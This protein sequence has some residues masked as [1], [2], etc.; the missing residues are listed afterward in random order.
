[1][2]STTPRGLQETQREQSKSVLRLGML[3]PG[4]VFWRIT[5]CVEAAKTSIQWKNSSGEV[6]GQTPHRYLRSHFQIPN[7]VWMACKG[8]REIPVP[9]DKPQIGR[10]KS[11]AFLSIEGCIYSQESRP[12]K[13]NRC[14]QLQGVCLS[15]EF[16]CSPFTIHQ[17]IGHA[18]SFDTGHTLSKNANIPAK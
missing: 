2:A 9:M 4:S 12:K 11:N 18:E 3:S 5:I 6:E 7:S 16:S 1:M 17:Q 13:T 8:Q 14:G 10:C 15:N